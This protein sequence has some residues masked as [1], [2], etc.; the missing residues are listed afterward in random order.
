MVYIVRSELRLG[1]KERGSA[2]YVQKECEP[3]HAI[4]ET[5]FC[6]IR[7]SVGLTCVVFSTS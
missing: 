6:G 3:G 4:R 1:E 2:K 5:T 7:I